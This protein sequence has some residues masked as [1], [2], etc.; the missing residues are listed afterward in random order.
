MGALGESAVAVRVLCGVA[1]TAKGE[2][3]KRGW[4]GRE[5][6]EKRDPRCS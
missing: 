5:C 4:T 2:K 6:E 3:K 1:L